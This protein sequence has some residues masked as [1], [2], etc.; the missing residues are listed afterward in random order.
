MDSGLDHTNYTNAS[1]YLL[2]TAPENCYNLS[3]AGYNFS[4]P[5]ECMEEDIISIDDNYQDNYWHGTFGFRAISEG[6][7]GA[8]NAKIVPVKTN[9]GEDGSV[10]DMICALYHAID[11]N[12]D[13]INMSAGF[14]GTM[15]IVEDAIYEAKRKGIFIVAAAGNKGLNLDYNDNNVYPAKFVSKERE[16][17]NED[18]SIEMITYDNLIS[19]AA[20]DHE[21][22][23]ADFSNYGKESVTLAAP[24]VN[25]AG[26]GLANAV[27][28]KS[29]TSQAAFFVSQVLAR[30]IARDNSRSLEDIRAYFEAN[31]LEDNETL[32]EYTITGKKIPF[33][34]EVAQIPG[35]TNP[36][37][38]NYNEDATE[39]DGSC[40]D[41][42]PDDCTDC[43]NACRPCS[44]LCING[45]LDDGEDQ[46]D[47]GGT[48][49]DC[50]EFGDGDEYDLF[51]NYPFLSQF[52]DDGDCTGT[53]IEVFDFGSYVFALVTTDDGTNL[54]SD[55]YDG[56]FATETAVLIN[57]T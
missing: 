10:F 32:S 41:C 39:N 9:N 24:G 14:G 40:M 13:V 23:L 35:C 15:D 22:N 44:L 6:L 18:G 42:K 1:K 2:S 31:Y 53:Q 29:G 25:I 26:Y 16:I 5:Y 30:E 52:V 51:S 37:A 34:W 54:Y 33:N 57:M 17:L 46:I 45:L 19:V 55:Y 3:A 20:V 21:G 47:C 12:A 8:S 36:N 48:C 28:V 4:T 56:Y 43:S 38:C 11:H 27:Q 50:E 7:T 49:P